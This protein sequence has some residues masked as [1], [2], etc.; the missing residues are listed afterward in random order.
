MLLLRRLA[1]IGLG[2]TLLAAPALAQSVTVMVNG[3][4]ITFDQPPVMRAG[5][6]YVPLRG[7]FQQLGA[8]V[9]YANGIINAQG[10]GRSVH[11][12]IGSNQ[13]T[14]NGSPVSLDSPP[15]LVGART[16]V[17]LRFVSQALGANVNW[18]NANS[19][20]YITHA[21]GGGPNPIPTQNSGIR[22]VDRDPYPTAISTSPIIKA[23][24]T[25]P[26]NRDSLR[27]SLDGRDL[28]SLTYASPTS[29]YVS[30]NYQLGLGEHTVT[31]SGTTQSGEQ[32]TRSWTFNARNAT[33]ANFIND[34][35]P[36]PNSSGV[37]STFTLTGATLPGSS[38]HIVA[39]GS[40]NLFG[41]FQVGSGTY[42]TDTQA[43]AGG[44]F[45]AQISLSGGSGSQVRVLIRSTSP[46]GASTTRVVTYTM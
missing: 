16:L 46:A 39:Q 31:V 26:I 10:N 13:A 44:I 29:F 43:S 32:F 21:G 35:R 34:V 18:N 3:S 23:S 42:Q 37:G 45:R 5:R 6:V 8:T 24:F 9:V 20:V 27:V 41:V 40:Q 25:E 22:L 11:L 12:R 30:P 14:I 28:T 38:I 1:G 36:A 2:L 17:P 7:V 15:F 33:G 19:T 4:P